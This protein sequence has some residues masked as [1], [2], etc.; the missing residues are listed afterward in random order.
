MNKGYYHEALDRTH[1][2]IQMIQE[3]LIEHKATQKH[4]TIKTK[5]EQAGQLLADVY[6]DFGQLF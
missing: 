6:Q 2:I 1:V 4:K 3:H 5:V